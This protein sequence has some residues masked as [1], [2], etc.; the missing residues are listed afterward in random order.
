MKHSLLSTVLV[1]LTGIWCIPDAY[2]QVSVSGTVVEA[3]TSSPLPGVTILE[4]GTNNG[5]TTDVDGNFTLNVKDGNSVLTFSYIGYALEEVQVGNQSNIRVGM[6]QDLTELQ[7]VVVTALGI[8]QEKKSLTYSVAEVESEA[9]STVKQTN[10]VNSLAGRVAGV[11]I[12]QN[13]GGPGSSSRVI[14]RGNNSLTGD[15]QPL[16]VI[17]GIPVDNSMH[18]ATVDNAGEYAHSDYGNGI[19]VVNP[20]NIESMTVLKGPNAAALYG[21]RAANGV[22]MITTKKGRERQ[23]LGVSYSANF[24][25]EDPFVLP[26]YQNQ[27][28]QGTLGQNYTN[29]KDLNLTGSS[30]GAAF[31]G[32]EQ[33]YY[34]G[35][36]RPYVAQEDNI[37][38]FFET[39]SNLINTIALDG[40]NEN[41]N[42]RFSYT[43]TQANSI[44]PNSD[45][46]RHNFNLRTSAYLTDKL[47]VDAKI[48]YSTQ[49]SQNRPVQGTEGIM[50]YVYDIPRNVALSDLKD[51]QN[52]DDFSVRTYGPTT[53]GN[54]YWIL[55]NDINQDSKNRVLG[56]IKAQYDFTPYLSAFVRV[57]T[58][59]TNQD[60]QKVEKYGHWFYGTGRFNLKEFASSET[61]ADFLLM[62]NKTFDETIGVNIN[63]G[64]NHRYSTYKSMGIYGDKFKVP[65]LWSLPNAGYTSPSY[66]PLMEKEV[67]SLYATATFSYNNL[68][69]LNLSGRNDWSSALSSDNWSYFYPSIGGAFLLNELIDPSH[70]TV[71]LLKIRASWAQ[72]G[73]D[74]GPYQLTNSYNLSLNGYLGLTSMTLPSLLL[75]PDLKPESVSTFEVGAETSFFNN[76]LY[77]SLTYYDIT[78]EDLIMDVPLDKNTSY[79]NFRTNVGEMTNKGI[80]VM[81]GGQP[82]N[83][84]DF[85]WDVSLNMAR[86]KNKLVR[87]TEGLEL[88]TF[89]TSN[90]GVIAVQ[91][92]VGGGFGE[93][94]GTTYQRTDDGRLILDAT[95]SPL[96][97]SERVH[98]GNYQPDLTGGFSNNF[99]YKGFGLNVLI[100]ARIGGEVYVGTEAGLDAAGVTK[101]TLQYR[102]EEIVMEG[103]IN[104]G[105]PDAPEYVP[106]TVA[107]TGQQYWG[108]YSGIASNYVY[109][110]TNIRLREAS[111]NYSLPASLLEKTPFA[112]GSIGIV[113]RN[114]FFLYSKIDH[115]DPESSF[116]SDAYGQGVLYYNLPTTRQ[117]G[118]NINL[119]F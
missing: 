99:R 91:A 9:F 108:A 32:S 58:D 78:S 39:G 45:L 80:E 82:V 25:W 113:G 60:I 85:S 42:F 37:K 106:N 63:V 117:Y 90:S 44:L 105:T 6:I 5:T 17:D 88:F 101:K 20:D 46:S 119:R 1:L 72:V 15:N 57:G 26:D 86:N 12:T 92:S 50:A 43:N 11:V 67:N 95:G 3:A 38:D 7:E 75:S 93:I 21:S 107:L 23:G 55:N 24:T 69:F 35:E 19:G 66:T 76:R 61:N 87:L 77:A 102:G 84:G 41:A 96:A 54:P 52:E 14:I 115:Y 62:F 73:N 34:T 36:T 98:L 53:S 112:G 4:K 56:F 114:L 104:E 71:D 18:G 8:E 40:G 10:A 79:S 29:A 110:Q 89:T 111:L 33:V 81:I 31:D 116:S 30:W 70:N 2:G 83:T 64:G 48:T 27:Y 103:V 28:G 100:D 22:I 16:Y 47:F 97:T 94:W 68:F 118:V 49:E 59:R 109:D 51:F 13:T 65:T 74:T